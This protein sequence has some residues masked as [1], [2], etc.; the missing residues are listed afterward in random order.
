MCKSDNI[1]DLMFTDLITQIQIN[2]LSCGSFLY[3]HCTVDFIT[4]IPRDEPKTKTITHR[5]LKILIQ[6][7]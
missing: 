2:D 6:K 5:K 4:T 1:L 7:T 3:D